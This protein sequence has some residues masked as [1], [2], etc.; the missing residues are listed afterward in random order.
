MKSH[1]CMQINLALL[2]FCITGGNSFMEF[3]ESMREKEPDKIYTIYVGEKAHKRILRKAFY[4]RHLWGLRKPF[5]CATY[6]HILFFSEKIRVGLT[7]ER[8]K[9]GFYDCCKMKRKYSNWVYFFLWKLLDR[10]DSTSN[11]HPES[12]NLFQKNFSPSFSTA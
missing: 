1:E 12:C 5:Y 7:K 11:S 4:E 2:K 3:Y 8:T 9:Q 6:S 10:S